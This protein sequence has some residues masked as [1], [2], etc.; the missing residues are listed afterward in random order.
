MSLETAIQENTHAIRELI[1]TIAQGL[2]ATSA[3]VAAVVKA[4]PKAEKVEVKKAEEKKEETAAPV[5]DFEA[6][7]KPFLALVNA[8]GNDVA[9]ELLA[10][11]GVPAGG[12]LGAVAPER[13]PDMLVAI[14]KAMS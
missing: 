11:F 7:K 10:Q 12:K 9:R 2:P 3:Q 1:A 6:V 13:Y 14:K 4:A 8:K 5:V